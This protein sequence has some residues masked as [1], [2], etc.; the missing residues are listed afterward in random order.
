MTQHLGPGMVPDASMFTTLLAL[1]AEFGISFPPVIAGVFRA[2]VT[3][4]GTLAVLA[5]GFQIVDETRALASSWLGGLFAPSSLRDTATDELLALLPALRRLPRRLD[6][7]SSSLERG[8]LSANI[9]LFADTRD[10]SFIAS[11][12][13]RT[14]MALC[15]ATLGLM[16][17][18]L[19][20][21]HD[22][23]LLL[24]APHSSGITVL[25]LLGY[26]G[27]FFSSVLILRVVIATTREGITPRPRTGQDERLDANAAAW[28]SCGRGQPGSARCPRSGR[29]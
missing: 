13:N 25:H 7:I 12:V 22:G 5:P 16:S 11:I 19:L 2:I 23:P 29:W 6:R 18:A 10:R 28:M 9:R 4:E 17:V 15:G 24:P 21:I 20:A 8:T 14:L 26:L 1:L 27:L 3:L